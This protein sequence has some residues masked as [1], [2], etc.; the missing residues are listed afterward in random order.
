VR[1]LKRMMEGMLVVNGEAREK[2]RVH[3]V[4]F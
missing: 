4:F 2:S 3:R 1:L